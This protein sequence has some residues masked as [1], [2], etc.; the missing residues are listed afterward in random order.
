MAARTIQG[1]SEQARANLLDRIVKH[2]PDDKRSWIFFAD[3]FATPQIAGCY[4]RF[5][6]LRRV[7]LGFAPVDQFVTRELFGDETTPGLVPIQAAN[8]V[9]AVSPL[10]LHKSDGR[11]IVV[12][13]ADRIGVACDVEPVA[14]PADTKLWRRQELVHEPLGSVRAVVGEKLVHAVRSRWQSGQVKEQPP[15]QS[16]AI[17]I[18]RH[19]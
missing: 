14:S 9:I 7:L 17:G 10:S 4:Q 6:D 16:R 3:V 2:G 15:R 12:I 8:H 5:D 19:R 11:T 1:Q 18:G 13:E